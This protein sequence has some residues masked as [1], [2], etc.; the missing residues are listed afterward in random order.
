MAQFGDKEQQTEHPEIQFIKS[1]HQ[2]NAVFSI[3][4]SV[5][6]YIIIPLSVNTKQG[7]KDLGIII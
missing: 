6:Y 2:M 4:S 7:S 3:A 1:L 5:L